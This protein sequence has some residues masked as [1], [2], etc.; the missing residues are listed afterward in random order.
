[1]ATGRFMLVVDKALTSVHI[2]SEYSLILEDKLF[3]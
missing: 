3:R 1:M 2:L